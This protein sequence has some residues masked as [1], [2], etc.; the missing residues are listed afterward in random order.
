MVSY[1]HYIFH[2]YYE[3][4]SPPTLVSTG[5]FCTQQADIVFVLDSSGSVTSEG[6]DNVL[7]FLQNLIEEM[8]IGPSNIQVSG[9][10]QLN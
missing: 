7:T 10:L 8:V 2:S 6:W 4:G 3:Y 5:V 9:V 1:M